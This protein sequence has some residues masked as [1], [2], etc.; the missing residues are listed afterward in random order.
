MSG[1]DIVI[2]PFRT[3]P[4]EVVA[5]LRGDIQM[6]VDFYAALKPS[7]QSG[8]ARALATSGAAAFAG[9]ARIFRPC[10]EAGVP[11]FDVTSWNA[12]YAPAGTPQPII[13]KLN[14][15]LHEVLADPDLKKR[16]LDLGIDAKGSTPAEIDARMR[17][18]IAKWAKV[19]EQAPH[20]EAVTIATKNEKG[21]GESA[22]PGAI[23]TADRA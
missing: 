15:A 4:D 22:M 21:R 1:A 5:L 18:D 2:V 6:E 13:D 8:Q 12:L 20:S 7:L 9:T 23:E 11:D 19:I 10:S 3:S 16:A 14:A 17:S